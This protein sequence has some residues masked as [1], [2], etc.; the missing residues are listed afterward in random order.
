VRRD[1]EPLQLKSESEEASKAISF[2]PS[3]VSSLASVST[4]LQG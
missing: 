4:L 2:Q 3:A 1:L